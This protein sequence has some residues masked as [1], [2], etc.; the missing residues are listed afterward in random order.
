[1]EL[2]IGDIVRIKTKE[3]INNVG[4]TEIT[5]DSDNMDRFCGTIAIITEFPLWEAGGTVV[6]V[7]IDEAYK[8]IIDYT[9]SPMWIEKTSIT[10]IHRDIKDYCEKQY[11]IF[12]CD[13][14][15][16]LRKYKI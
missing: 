10:S 8:D 2:E 15:C 13:K 7:S 9:F 5:W 14:D 4:N 11:L 16:I 1:M 6:L 12:G 3:E